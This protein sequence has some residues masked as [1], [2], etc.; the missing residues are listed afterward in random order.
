M[1][2]QILEKME[3]IFKIWELK[4]DGTILIYF[5][6][7]GIQR[8]DSDFSRR[9][10]FFLITTIWKTLHVIPHYYLLKISMLIL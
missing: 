10:S 9:K 5:P 4:I 3:K 7:Q 2:V 8:T 1:V 6:M